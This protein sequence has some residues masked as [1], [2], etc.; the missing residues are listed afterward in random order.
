MLRVAKDNL[1]L[2][3]AA[4]VTLVRDLGDRYGVNHSV[5][6]EEHGVAI[7]SV[8]SGLRKRGRYGGFMAREVSS[9][10]EITVAVNEISQSA[11]DLKVILTG[12]ID[13]QAGAVKGSPQFAAEELCFITDLA[14]ERGLRTVVHCSGV[15]GL[16]RAVA[17]G[18]DSI[19]HGFFMTRSVLEGM[20]DRNIAWTPTISPVYFQWLRPELAGWDQQTV[21]NLR[22]I[23]DR[24]LEHIALAAALGVPLVAGSDAGSHGVVHG[25]ALIDELDFLLEAGLPME[26]VLS[27]ATSVPRL[28]WGAEPHNLSAGRRAEFIALRGS[29]LVDPCHLHAVEAVYCSNNCSQ[30]LTAIGA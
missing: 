11:D 6:A 28:R 16:E 14:R 22:R 15:E 27:A 25:A 20:A 21:A 18:V 12:I 7:R 19:E 13:F 30:P 26:T 17:A 2:C 29:P 4:G 1:L 24:H 9:L 23:L 3:R 5:R 8:G 10:Q